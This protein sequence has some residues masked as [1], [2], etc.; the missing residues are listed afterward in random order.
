MAVLNLFKKIKSFFINQNDTFWLFLLLSLAFIAA[1]ITIFGGDLNGHNY[2]T[3]FFYASFVFIFVW[4]AFRLFFIIKNKSFFETRVLIVLGL[5][6]LVG[7]FNI[8]IQTPF[9]SYSFAY[10]K[11]VIITFT[12]LCLVYLCAY[13][14]FDHLL[15]FVFPLI[16]TVLAIEIAISYFSGIGQI[17]ANQTNKALLYFTF[18][19]SNAAG[20]YFALII[21][22]NI[23]GIFSFKQYYWK[24]IFIICICFLCYLLY[25][26][27]AR[28]AILGLLLSGFVF[29]LLKINS[30]KKIN[31]YD[32]IVLSVSCVLPI[33]FICVYTFLGT[34]TNVLEFLNSLFGGQ[35]K[36][37]TSRMITWVSAFIHLNG[38]HFLIGDYYK[39]TSLALDVGRSIAGYQNSQID[40]FVD[41]GLIPALLIISFLILCL[42]HR[43]RFINKN[44]TINFLPSALWLFVI[45][46]SIFEGGLF[47][48][49]NVWY[50]FGFSFLSLNGFP[51]KKV[52]VK[53]DEPTYYEIIV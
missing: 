23:Y 33:V 14:K 49:M 48:C 30:T 44:K 32:L 35:G 22:I 42:Y 19:N 46:S 21:S 43:F 29:L 36:T 39:S 11:K 2:S 26:T 25:K 24:A 15:K 34:K 16:G 40:Y 52:L 47:I 20:I 3:P 31:I 4:F 5:A 38:V 13:G 12:V 45:F 28:N 10:F 8:F 7:A 18:G 27:H 41:F 50:L 17:Y 53:I 37:I 1:S 6:F 51:E 9:S